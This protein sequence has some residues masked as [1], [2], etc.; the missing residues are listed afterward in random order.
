MVKDDKSRLVASLEIVT[1]VGL[2]L[3]WIAFFTVGLA[4]ENATPCYFAYEHS[5]PL[6]DVILAVALLTAGILLMRSNPAGRSLSLICAGALI[7]LGLLD[8]SFNLQNGIYLASVIDL[9]LNALINLWCVGFGLAACIV[10][11][12][13]EN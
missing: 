7:F 8:F 6:P 2:I 5:F 1:G 9:V 3:F 4:P 11:G 12:K 10:I 13:M